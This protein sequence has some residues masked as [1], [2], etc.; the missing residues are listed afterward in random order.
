MLKNSLAVKKKVW[1]LACVKKAV[2]SK[3]VAKCDASLLAKISDND[4]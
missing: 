2:K 3:V 4:Y 1:P